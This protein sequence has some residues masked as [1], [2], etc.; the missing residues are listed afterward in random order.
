MAMSIQH[1]SKPLL[2]IEGLSVGYGSVLLTNL[3]LE[4]KEGE[5]V[6]FMG[7]NGIGKS[8]LLKTLIGLV[9]PLAGKIQY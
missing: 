3:N 1:I 5:L 6:C 9:Q 2:K 8:T 4:L 7:S